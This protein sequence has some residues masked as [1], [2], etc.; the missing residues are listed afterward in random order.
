MGKMKR[1]VRISAGIHLI[2]VSDQGINDNIREFSLEFVEPV[3]RKTFQKM[4]FLG[5]SDQF[6]DIISPRL[7][8]MACS[9][10]A[11]PIVVINGFFI[12]NALPVA[13]T[14]R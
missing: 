12:K 9:A 1:E 10:E 3:K 8:V 5:D 11:V 6:A 2:A 4:A 14:L 7:T 13:C